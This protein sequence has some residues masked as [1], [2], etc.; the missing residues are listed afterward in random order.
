MLASLAAAAA[1]AGCSQDDSAESVTTAETAAELAPTTPE[2]L[3]TQ[4]YE[5][6]ISE[7]VD[8]SLTELA[9][10]YKV[11][12]TEEAVV[13]AVSRSLVNRFDAGPDALDDARAGCKQ[14]FELES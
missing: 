4:I 13:E 12:A 5:R 9:A 1:L 2:S 7:C 6:G 8:G 11:K 3:R 10:K 14:G